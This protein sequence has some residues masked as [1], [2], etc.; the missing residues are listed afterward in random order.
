MTVPVST[1]QNKFADDLRE[2]QGLFGSSLRLQATADCVPTVWAQ[3]D[4]FRDVLRFFKQQVSGPYR[5]LYDLTAID[6]RQRTHRG[7]Q[8]ASD[9]TVVYHLLSYER[10]EDLRVKV[11]LQDGELSLPSVTDLWW[12]ADWYEREVWD[13]FGVTFEGHPNLRRILMPPWWT[14]HPLRKEHP[15]RATETGP[16]RMTSQDADRME[17]MMKFRP[18]EWGL[19]TAEEDFDYLFLNLGPQHPGTH[20]ALRVILQLDGQRIVNSVCDIGYHHRGAEKMGERQTWHT[21]IPY[22]DRID[23]LGGVLNN[24]PY[25]LS[26][27]TLAGI[28]VPDRAKVIR[29]MT[30]EL[31]RIISHLVYMGTLIQDIGA[32]SPVFYMFNDRE[33]AFDIIEAIS[34]ARMHPSYFR[35]GGVAMDLPD[36]WD[37]MVR[38]FVGYMRKRLDEYE[39][40]VMKNRIVKARTVGVG[41]LSIDDAIDWGA[42]GPMLRAAGYAWDYRHKRPYGGYEQFEFDIPTGVRG[43]CYDRARVHME[44]MRQSLRIIQ[45]C[46]ENMPAGPCQSDHHLATPPRKEKTMADIETLIHHFLDVSWGPVIPPGEATVPVEAAKGTNSYYLISDGGGTSYRTRIRTPSFNHIQLVPALCRGLMLPDLIAILG[47]VDF[48]LADVD[49]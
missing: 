27:E 19:K 3:R 46:L 22:T 7:D 13:M 47:A 32:M 42:T 49:R 43:D 36:G 1:I 33:R 40:M 38:D 48:V 44:E 31:F 10:N 14:G 6:E 8:P 16:F 34:G 41:E 24:F 21:Y 45:Q 30:A 12:T 29:I 18:Q 4:R 25:V 26:V 2:M 23:Y 28:A 9:F 20:G 39:G 37:A 15:S 11:P 17:E 5:T 35:I